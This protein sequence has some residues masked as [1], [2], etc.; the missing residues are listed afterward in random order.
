[1][2]TNLHFS[3]IYLTKFSEQLCVFAFCSLDITKVP[4]IVIKSQ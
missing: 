2:F 3:G 4:N 1:M